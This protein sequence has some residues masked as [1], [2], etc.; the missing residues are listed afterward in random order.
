MQGVSYDS[1]TLAY[2]HPFVKPIGL[3]A[4]YLVI[5]IVGLAIA[6]LFTWKNWYPY[7]YGWIFHVITDMATHVSDAQPVLWPLSDWVFPTPVS[8]WESAY[9]GGEFGIVNLVLA[10]LSYRPKKRMYP[11]ANQRGK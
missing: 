6:F 9:Y 11:N 3:F 2:E 8:Y 4:Y 1:W 7:V 10:P 5:A